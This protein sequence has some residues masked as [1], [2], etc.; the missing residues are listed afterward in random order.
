MDENIAS[1]HELESCF[2][3]HSVNR[4]SCHLLYF[5][6]ALWMGLFCVLCLIVQILHAWQCSCL[7]GGDLEEMAPFRGSFLARRNYLTLVFFRAEFQCAAMD[8]DSLD[9]LMAHS[10][11]PDGPPRVGPSE[12]ASD[13]GKLSTAGRVFAKKQ[14]FPL[15]CLV[16]L[17]TWMSVFA[18]NSFKKVNL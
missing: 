6:A 5:H 8:D 18:F 3:F 17:E 12:L 15:V 1:L 2:T 4:S 7:Q 9:E 16:T 11:G 10:P 13:A 14:C